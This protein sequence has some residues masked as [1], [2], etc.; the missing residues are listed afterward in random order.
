MR[1]ARKSSMVFRSDD[2]PIN[3]PY[4]PD[5][6]TAFTTSSASGRARM[7]DRPASS[8]IR[9]DVLQNGIFAQIVLDESGDVRV[10]GFVI[11]DA[12]A[13]RVRKR[14]IAGAIG[15]HQ[16]RHADEGTG[17]EGKR[18]EKIVVDAAVDDIHARQAVDGLHID[19]I[20]D[21]H[22]IA[23]FHELDA[24]LL[25]EEAMLEVCAVVEARGEQHDDRALAA[26]GR[27]AAQYLDQFGRVVIDRQHLETLRRRAEKSGA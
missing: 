13:D 18:V 25:R 15:V 1:R 3:M 21:H 10:N 11:G 19:D 22:Q 20:V 24:H 17:A 16:S 2:G 5:S 8:K 4:P 12:R 26:A 14:D 23:A 6:P 27:E 7:R 9:L